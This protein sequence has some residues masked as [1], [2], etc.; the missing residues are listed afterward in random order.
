MGLPGIYQPP[1]SPACH[2]EVTPAGPGSP[3][4]LLLFP[5]GQ[6]SLQQHQ[7]SAAHPNG[8]E[9]P[10]EGGAG[11][12]ASPPWFLHRYYLW[13]FTFLR[14]D[15][16]LRAIQP[17]TPDLSPKGGAGDDIPPPSG[18]VFL[19]LPRDWDPGLPEKTLETHNNVFI[20]Q[21]RGGLP[22]TILDPRT[23]KGDER[24]ALMK[25]QDPEG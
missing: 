8:E 3:P 9:G 7:S 2:F 11:L 10:G 20:F 6:M 23:Q 1:W 21:A 24:V 13:V 19:I 14:F 17:P 25:T 5:W 12:R 22:H 4:P 18:S 15:P 16:F